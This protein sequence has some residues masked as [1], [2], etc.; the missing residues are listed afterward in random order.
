M[1]TTIINSIFIISSAALLLGASKL[2]FDIRIFDQIKLQLL[3]S[4][5]LAAR[6]SCQAI[7]K[8]RSNEE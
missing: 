2:E 3:T 4:R 7:G 8:E 6:P 1:A 5:M